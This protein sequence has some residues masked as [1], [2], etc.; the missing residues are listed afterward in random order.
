MIPKPKRKIDRKLLDSYHEKPCIINNHEC[1][2]Q[3]CAHHKKTKGAGGG[4]VIDNLYAL[5]SFHHRAIHDLGNYTFHI[6]Y[7]IKER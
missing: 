7:N 6:K 4:D 2:G 5:C 1:F 3:V